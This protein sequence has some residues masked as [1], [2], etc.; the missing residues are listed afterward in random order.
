MNI[1]M[2]GARAFPVVQAG[3]A[4]CDLLATLPRDAVI[5]TRGAERGVDAFVAEAAS[6]MDFKVKRFPAEGG[7]SNFIRDV[8][9]VKDADAV[10][11][12]F[13]ADHIGEGGTQHVVDKALDQHKRTYCYTWNG[14]SLVLVGSS[15]GEDHPEHDEEAD[16]SATEGAGE[17]APEQFEYGG[18]HEEER[19]RPVWPG[20]GR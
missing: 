13:E 9:M 1:V 3:V 2:V 10:Y 4:L 17:A 11:A 7:A 15:D 19:G 16:R 14:G 5:F 20:K 6:I 8:E 12:F 18:T